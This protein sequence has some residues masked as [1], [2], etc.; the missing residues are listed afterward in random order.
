MR[1]NFLSKRVHD[2]VDDVD[3]IQNAVG[4]C[5]VHM[6]VAFVP[7]ASI[8]KDSH[9]SV[10]LA[11]KS[12]SLNSLLMCHFFITSASSMEPSITL[13]TYL[14]DFMIAPISSRDAGLLSLPV[15]LFLIIS[16]VLYH[17]GVYISDRLI[18][19]IDIN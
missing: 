7:V 15:S 11:F 12:A 2:P 5:G 16:I 18:I 8:F 3:G 19:N 14:H 9:K 17:T 10:L 4:Y 6:H 13:S 1:R